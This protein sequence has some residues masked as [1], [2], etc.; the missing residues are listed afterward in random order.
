M[1]AAF[2]QQNDVRKFYAL[3]YMTIHIN[4]WHVSHKYSPSQATIYAHIL[5]LNGDIMCVYDKKLA[6]KTLQKLTT[7]VIFTV[8]Y[9]VQIVL[10]WLIKINSYVY[11]VYL[12]TGEI[13]H[14]LHIQTEYTLKQATHSHN[15]IFDMLYNHSYK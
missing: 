15:S 7:F 5:Y 10:T 2:T 4:M 11:N 13:P 12:D 9:Q 14:L 6:S 3:I 8:Q 1:L